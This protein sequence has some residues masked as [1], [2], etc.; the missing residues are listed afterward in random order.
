MI[1]QGTPPGA[2]LTRKFNGCFEAPPKAVVA[3]KGSTKFHHR[4]GRNTE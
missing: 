4:F 1:R 3:W 2:E